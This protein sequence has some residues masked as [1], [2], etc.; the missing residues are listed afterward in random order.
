MPTL[1]LS[2]RGV[3]SC[4]HSAA[5]HLVKCHYTWWI[6]PLWI[7]HSLHFSAYLCFPPNVPVSLFLDMVHVNRLKWQ[8]ILSLS[9]LTSHVVINVFTCNKSVCY[10]PEMRFTFSHQLQGNCRWCVPVEIVLDENCLSCFS[11]EDGF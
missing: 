3:T 9:W 2:E 1:M 5:V 10:W 4:Y 7:I 11:W 8:N 6:I